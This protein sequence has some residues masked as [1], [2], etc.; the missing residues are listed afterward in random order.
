MLDP[1]KR[2]GIDPLAAHVSYSQT[3]WTNQPQ[4]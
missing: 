3:R 4:P 2:L 1:I